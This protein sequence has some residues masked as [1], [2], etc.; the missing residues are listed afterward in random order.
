MLLLAHP[1]VA[2]RDCGHCQQFVYADSGRVE[3]DAEGKPLA[4]APGN[5]PPCRVQYAGCPKGTPEQQRSMSPRNERFYRAYRRAKLTGRWPDD[6]WFLALATDCAEI[7]EQVR[8]AD[9]IRGAEL[10][11]QAAALTAISQVMT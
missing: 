3:R 7:E 4:R 6:E 8:R 9:A 1:E 2:T 10:T 5:L 11:G